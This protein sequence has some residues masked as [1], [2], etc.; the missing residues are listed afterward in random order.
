[1]QCQIVFARSNSED[2]GDRC[3]RSAIHTCGQCGSEIC[4]ACSDSCYECGLNFCNPHPGV[5]VTC[6][7]DHAAATGHQTDL[8]QHRITISDE[9]IERL[10]ERVDA[11]AAA[12]RG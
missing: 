3:R 9:L 10:T 7:D 8:P 4:G 12:H 1:M 5:N 6:L 2:I 11:V